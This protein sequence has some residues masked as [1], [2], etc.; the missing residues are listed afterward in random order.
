MRRTHRRRL[1]VPALALTVGL[2]ALPG[3]ASGGSAERHRGDDSDTEQGE[4]QVSADKA[5]SGPIVTFDE[6]GGPGGQPRTLVV[7]PVGDLELRPGSYAP[8]RLHVDRRD[9]QQLYDLVESPGFTVMNSRYTSGTA[10]PGAG[11]AEPSLQTTD[12]GAPTMYRIS[13]SSQPARGRAGLEPE[14]KVVWLQEGAEHPSLLDGIVSEL[15]RLRRMVE[16]QGS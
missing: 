5:S 3:C 9:L 11:A 15:V 10:T 7:R 1:L 14:T 2:A 4:T 6:S 13:V 8:E 16:Q 12:P